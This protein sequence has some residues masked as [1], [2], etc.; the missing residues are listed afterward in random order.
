MGCISAA[1]SRFTAFSS[2]RDDRT[3]WYGKVAIIL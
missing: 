2:A 1:S 3:G